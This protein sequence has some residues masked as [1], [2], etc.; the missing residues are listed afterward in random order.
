MRRT[1]AAG[2]R[3]PLSTRPIG[4]DDLRA[5]DV[6]N[7]PLA[8]EPMTAVAAYVGTCGWHNPQWNPRV[9]P[10]GLTVEER[11]GHYAT[12]FSAVE[13]EVSH[14]IPSRTQTARWR[15]SVSSDFR[16]AAR[17]SH[18]LAQKAC[19]RH[20][21]DALAPLLQALEPLEEQLAALLIELPA[22]LPPMGD[23]LSRLLAALPHD[24]QYAFTLPDPQWHRREIYDL[25]GEFG[26]T[27]CVRDRD[28]RAELP[29]ASGKF[30]YARLPGP[31]PAGGGRYG[32]TALRGWATRVA[33]WQRKGNRVF[34]FFAN[35]ESGFAVK[36]AQ[37]LNS[38]LQGDG[39]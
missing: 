6:I 39:R 27:V 30:V 14:T 11:L 8:N 35:A 2:S 25:L 29:S 7:E 5:A 10:A 26:A 16:F 18:T 15:A 22:G 34:V 28:A 36:D 1:E 32:A 33:N 17:V 21:E 20:P 23:R 4:I 12:R 31:A 3:R 38:Y 9:L 13:L 24:R 37:L 19:S